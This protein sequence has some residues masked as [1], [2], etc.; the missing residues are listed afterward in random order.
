MPHWWTTVCPDTHP[1]LLNKCIHKAWGVKSA[2]IKLSQLRRPSKK[3]AIHMPP[4][5]SQAGEQSLNFR[6]PLKIICTAPTQ[7]A[8]S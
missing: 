8:E 4:A 5:E 6:Q 7:G 1:L 2:E 3:P